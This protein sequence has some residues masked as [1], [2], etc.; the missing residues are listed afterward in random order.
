MIDKRS[1]FTIVISLLSSISKNQIRRVVVRSSRQSQYRLFIQE[2]QNRLL[3]LEI[4]VSQ[5]VYRIQM[6]L[7]V[8][9][10]YPNLKLQKQSVNIPCELVAS[11][12]FA[13]HAYADTDIVYL[14]CQCY[15]YIST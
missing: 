1:W 6:L 8:Q 2:V 9:T 7:P 11:C 13:I 10:F 3:L 15:W 14:I 5:V 12:T 4:Q